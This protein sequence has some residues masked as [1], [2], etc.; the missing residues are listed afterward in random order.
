MLLDGT[1]V[2]ETAEKKGM[3]VTCGCK[4]FALDALGDH[5]TTCTSHSVTEKAHDW[6]LSKLLTTHKVK[7]QQKRGQWCGDIELAA[8]LADT[9]GPVPLVLDLPGV[10]PVRHPSIVLP[11]TY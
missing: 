4:K 5:V 11:S 3:D 10:S 7:T 2:P 6:G 9:V 8:Y 1:E